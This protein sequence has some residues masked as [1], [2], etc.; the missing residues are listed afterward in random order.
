LS[1]VVLAR[2]GE[3]DGEMLHDEVQVDLSLLQ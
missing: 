3:G 2:V 1:G